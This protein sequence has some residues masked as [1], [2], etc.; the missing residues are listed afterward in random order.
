MYLRIEISL[1]EIGAPEPGASEPEAAEDRAPELGPPLPDLDHN[2]GMGGK[3]GACYVGRTHTIVRL[4][5]R[6][7]RKVGTENFGG[8]YLYWICTTGFCVVGFFVPG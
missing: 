6:I 7:R 1:P 4:Q 8:S 3:S 5:T 2:A